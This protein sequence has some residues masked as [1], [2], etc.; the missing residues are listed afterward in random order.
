MD[1]K[2]VFLVALMWLCT[3]R[4]ADVKGIIVRIEISLLIQTASPGKLGCF[5]EHHSLGIAQV[6]V[7]ASSQCDNKV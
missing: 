5:N 7:M 2:P 6:C 1:L 3:V 4:V